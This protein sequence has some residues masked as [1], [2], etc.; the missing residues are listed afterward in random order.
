MTKA[1]IVLAAA[2][3][4]F[5]AGCFVL[6][7]DLNAERNRVSA[8]EAQVASLQRD[9]KAAAVTPDTAS[10]PTSEPLAQAAT[11]KPAVAAQTPSSRTPAA[12]KPA[13]AEDNKQWRAVLADPEYRKARLAEHRLRMQRGYPEIV[14]ALG[15]SESEAERF[16]DLLAQQSL[17]D[18]ELAIAKQPD[19]DPMRRRRELH[20]QAEKVRQAF[21]GEER[22]R[23]WVEY[24]NS[25]GARGFVSELRTELATTSSPLREEQ[26]KP[27][28]KALAAEHQ[29]HEAERQEN[30]WGFRDAHD[31]GG[32]QVETPASEQI[33]Y[34]ERRATMIEESLQRQQEAAE[35]YLDSVQQRQFN[36][37]VEELRTARLSDR[38]RR[39]TDRRMPATTRG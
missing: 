17:R 30:Y 19:Q 10:A 34:M 38:R 12:A 2:A 39:D 33:A 37:L 32:Q 27:L 20:A 31:V 13:E 3:V 6:F 35:M 22:F 7:K 1:N 36:A 14:A 16:L 28:I 5:A 15:L 24:V 23:T 11:V 29:R 18:N 8:L 26:V 21:L 9:V 25:A 4:V